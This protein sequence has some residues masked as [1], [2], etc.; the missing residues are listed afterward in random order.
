MAAFLAAPDRA[1][2]RLLHHRRINC[3]SFSR[4]FLKLSDTMNFSLSGLHVLAKLSAAC[5]AV[6][7]CFL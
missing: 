5:H 1:I 3:R 6:G 7:K 4:A 2:N